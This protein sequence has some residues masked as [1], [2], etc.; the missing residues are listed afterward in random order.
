MINTEETQAVIAP[1]V[2]VSKK[3][4]R[5]GKPKVEPTAE[6]A[7][8]EQTIPEAPPLKRQRSGLGPTDPVQEPAAEKT[9]EVAAVQTPVAPA[10]QKK[11]KGG[12]RVKKVDSLPSETPAV[13]DN[14]KVKKEPSKWAIVTPKVAEGDDDD[15]DAETVVAQQLTMDSAAPELDEVAQKKLAIKLAKSAKMSKNLKGVYMFLTF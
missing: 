11:S 2:P 7:A 8:V 14:V 1:A 5:G 13:Q 15:V 6:E 3:R 10:T 12:R 9:T 4:S